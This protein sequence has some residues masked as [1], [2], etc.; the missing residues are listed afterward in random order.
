MRRRS[1]WLGAHAALSLVAVGCNGI[2]GIEELTYDGND[3]STDAN[4][5]ALTEG[6]TDGSDGQT[7]PV[8]VALSSGPV[9]TCAVR[10]DGTLWCWGSAYGIELTDLCDGAVEPS[11]ARTPKQVVELQNVRNVAVGTSSSCALLEDGTVSCW[12]MHQQGQLG[13]GPAHWS[14]G[15]EKI[16]CEP[17][18]RLVQGLEN[19]KQV[20]LSAGTQRSYG[21]AVLQD[22]TVKCWG[23]N[24]THQLASAEAAQTCEDITQGGMMLPCS[25]TPVL[26]PGLNGVESISLAETHACALLQ[27]KTLRCWGIAHFGQLGAIG[28]FSDCTFQSYDVDATISFDVQCAD[29]P[30]QVSFLPGYGGTSEVAVN[31]LAIWGFG[32]AR[33]SMIN[34]LQCWGDDSAGELGTATAPDS[35]SVSYDP[36]AGPV[37]TACA[38]RPAPVPN[39]VNVQTVSAGNL[40]ACAVV[41]G[42]VWCWGADFDH[43]LGLAAPP[44]V[45]SLDDGSQIACAKSPQKVPG[46]D[47]VEKLALGLFHTCALR[48]DGSVWCWGGNGLGQLGDGDSVESRVEP[49]PVVW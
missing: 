37:V 38:R 7:D 34:S 8:V 30:R 22:G 11:C 4:N 14:C 27:D 47:G 31:G 2:L 9:A 6:G 33:A 35:C 29:T 46:V 42:E 19:V 39:L 3:A 40:H 20:A 12:G 44:D 28:T 21:C 18:P 15:P 13:V 32:C 17:K 25:R 16:P 26:V 10:S 36:D 41:A 43:A 23:V 48:T 24:E 1:G 45:C 49:M 5:D